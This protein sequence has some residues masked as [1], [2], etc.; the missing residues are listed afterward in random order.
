MPQT[1]YCR[2][3]SGWMDASISWRGK[4]CLG[5]KWERVDKH[6][7]EKEQTK[8]PELFLAC[9]CQAI[10]DI[11]S[12]PNNEQVAITACRSI[13]LKNGREF[14]GLLIKILSPFRASGNRCRGIHYIFRSQNIWAISGFLSFEEH[15]KDTTP[16]S[17]E[18][19][20]DPKT[21]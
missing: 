5:E 2:K 9:D 8:V 6:P 15:S 16:W 11:L 21:F 18:D 20:S 4:K 13:T 14:Y 3:S 17:W 7:E 12:M 1:S 19:S 10:S